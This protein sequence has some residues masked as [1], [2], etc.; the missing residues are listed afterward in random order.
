MALS[1]IDEE[2]K[3]NDPLRHLSLHYEEPGHPIA[4]NAAHSIWKY[5]N[6]ALSLKQI[7]HFL[8]KHDSFTKNKETRRP[9]EFVP[10]Y[11]RGLRQQVH[12]DLFEF[13]HQKKDNPE[14]PFVLLVIDNYSK[15]IWCCPL[16]SKKGPEVTHQF[17][18]LYKDKT[19]KIDNLV[20]DKGG[21]FYNKHFIDFCQA[22][23]INMVL[24]RTS[25]K[26]VVAERA[27]RSIKGL[28]SRWMT[29]FDSRAFVL[30]LPDIVNTY[31]KR[32][33]RSIN[34]TPYNIE[35]SLNARR[36]LSMRL[37]SKYSNVK[38]KKPTLELHDLVRIDKYKDK[39][40]RGFNQRFSDEIFIIQGISTHLPLPF[41]TLS[42]L[43][44]DEWIR[45]AFKSS[46]LTLV[47]LSRNHHIKDII[48]KEDPFWTVTFL[49]LPSRYKARVHSKNIVD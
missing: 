10:C 32:F 4:F 31:N 48:K 37:E 17:K 30:A 35:T 11:V 16:S 12:A 46:E 40:S 20:T 42:N 23:N 26:A 27:I 49:S 33:H 34:N 25:G 9:R 39:L 22:E 43:F 45:G 44:E 38:K 14:F 21:E 24:P 2:L 36:K 19:G 3:R 8:Q 15:Y 18:K 5:Y 41:Y 6:K 13:H 1:I 28:I 47:K 7:H 29:N